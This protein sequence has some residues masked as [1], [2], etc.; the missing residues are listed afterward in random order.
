MGA[1]QVKGKRILMT[2]VPKKGD[3]IWL[4]FDP[5][6]GHEVIKRR[7]AFVISREIFNVKVNM[8]IVAPI[9]SKIH[10]VPLECILPKGLKTAGS[11]LVYQMKS[12]DIFHRKAVFIEKA[13]SSII[14]K[15]TQ[16]AQLIVT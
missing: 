16:L 10:H 1:H 9:T 3:I 6:G 12:L 11:V 2:Y 4:D 14:E 5:S 15:V 13:P 8:A 7:P